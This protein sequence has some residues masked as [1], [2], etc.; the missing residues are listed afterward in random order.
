M[1][2]IPGRI[3]GE[4]VDLEG[5]R[6]FVL[7]LQAREQHIRR[8]KA[9]SNICTNQALASLATLVAILWYGKEGVHKLALTNYQ[10]TAYLRSSLAG[11]N[12]IKIISGGCFFNEF[13]VS[14]GCPYKDVETHFNKFGIVPGLDLSLFYPEFKSSLL[15]AVTEIKGKEDLDKYIEVAKSLV[16][17]V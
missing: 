12:G 1:R 7:T 14:F 11:I 3:V 13:V 17:S 4:T 8:E 5:K 2:Q 9:T 10:R 15:I 6:G 16:I